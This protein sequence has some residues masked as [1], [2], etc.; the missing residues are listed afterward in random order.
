LS[1]PKALYYSDKYNEERNTKEGVQRHLLYAAKGRAKRR[2]LLF[3][4]SDE[5][6]VVPDFCP[7]L[8]IKLERRDDGT[9]GP[10]DCSPTLDRIDSSLG[11]IPGNVRIISH[12]ANRYKNDMTREQ[13]QNI[14]DYLDGK[15]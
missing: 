10:Q 3:T 8:N 5:D 13:L 9:R 15:L 6:I 1:K 11:Y 7:I 4:I 14:L 2:N 12:K